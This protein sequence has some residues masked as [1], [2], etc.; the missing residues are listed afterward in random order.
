MEYSVIYERINDG[1][2]PDIFFYAHIPFLDITTHGEGIEGARKA[3]EE[4]IEGWLVEKIANGEAIPQESDS[5]FSKIKI[6]NALL[7]A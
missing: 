4:L 1:S 7:S 6:D 3:A 5:Y 2:L